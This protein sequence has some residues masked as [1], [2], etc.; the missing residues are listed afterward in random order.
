MGESVSIPHA[1]SPD[2]RRQLFRWASQS[3]SALAVFWAAAA[4]SWLWMIVKA[5]SDGGDFLIIWTG[6][7]AFDTGHPMYSQSESELPFVF[8]PSAGL[9]L[10]PLGVLPFNVAMTLFAVIQAIAISLACVLAL[11]LAGRLHAWTIPLAVLAGSLLLPARNSM[12]LGNVD[13]VIVALELVMLLAAARNRWFWAATAFGVALALKPVVLPLAVIFILARHWKMLVPALLIPAV[14]SV[15][16]MALGSDGIAFVTKVLPYLW[17]GGASNIQVVN[18][19]RAGAANNYLHLPAVLIVLLRLAAAAAIAALLLGA[20]RRAGSRV[21]AGI[22]VAEAASI[23]MLGVL[24]AFSYSWTHYILFLLPLFALY[25]FRGSIVR[26]W[27]AAVAFYL[28][29]FPD[30]PLWA[31][32]S[33]PLSQLRLTF[34]MVLLAAALGWALASE[35]RLRRSN[36]RPAAPSAAAIRQ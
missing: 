26:G 8:P 4:V 5:R 6:I 21:D 35:I 15:A 12:W 7:R 11:Q 2:R 31:R 9:L 33:F 23:V 3:R 19:S 30:D 17:G 13:G 16:A 25:G 27:M 34:G 29:L 1:A 28:L 10:A 14:L 24:L 32:I 22:R 20:W 18:I 36:E